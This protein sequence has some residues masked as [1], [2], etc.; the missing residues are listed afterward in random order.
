MSH[1]LRSKWWSL[2][3]LAGALLGCGAIEAAPREIPYASVTFD[4]TVPADTPTT[5]SVNVVGSEPVL[6]EGT[7]PGFHLR[8]GADGH[9]TGLVRLAV[10]TE[11]SF[12]LR[13]EEGWHPEVSAQGEPIPRRAFR[14]EG[15]MTVPVR[16]SRW[17]ASEPI[18]GP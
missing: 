4:V 18:T 16:V 11:V 1:S 17:G 8:R 15:D 2:L 3:P 6:G 13:R 5:T 7:A 10:D 9:Y 14:V 12:E